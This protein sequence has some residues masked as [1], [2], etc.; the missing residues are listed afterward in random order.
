MGKERRKRGGERMK[1]GFRLREREV[2]VS[3]CSA[4]RIRWKREVRRGKSRTV[5]G[6][7]NESMI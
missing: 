4:A 1:F 7:F 3:Y 2:E 5:S 6:Y